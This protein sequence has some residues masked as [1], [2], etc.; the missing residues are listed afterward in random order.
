MI[1]SR[2]ASNFA[3]IELDSA[4]DF[5]RWLAVLLS[6]SPLRA[7]GV[8]NRLLRFRYPNLD[9]PV[10]GSSASSSSTHAEAPESSNK[11]DSK[12]TQ[13]NAAVRTIKVGQFELWDPQWRQPVTPQQKR[14]KQ[15]SSSSSS[16][17]ASIPESSKNFRLWIKASCLLKTN[18]E[19]QIFPDLHV[20]GTPQRI[21][22][23]EGF[24]FSKDSKSG[25]VRTNIPSQSSHSPMTG[26]ST[27][28]S[29]SSSGV[30]SSFLNSN[31]SHYT[32]QL[33][34]VRR[35]AIQKADP[36]LTGRQNCIVI[37]LKTTVD[38]RG[39]S[40]AGAYHAQH[41][42]NP[43]LS[44]SVHHHH[45]YLHHQPPT[46]SITGD[47]LSQEPSTSPGTSVVVTPAYFY[48]EST[49]LMEVWFVL[50]RSMSLPEL[51]G[52]ETGKVLGSFRQIRTL[53]VRIIDGKIMSPRGPGLSMDSSYMPKAIDS[54]VDISLNDKV[55]ARTRVKYGSEKPFWRE[56][57]SFVYVL[58]VY[59]FVLVLY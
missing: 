6:W 1:S 14:T 13:I 17:S 5:N 52:P 12:Q 45:Q 19:L 29:T 8:A 7:A 47:S 16:S 41:S 36:S 2:D 34:T 40:P 46:I 11:S 27:P 3:I 55:R 49:T 56:D 31:S 32:I 20:H 30:S 57:F 39:V 38:R 18:G 42:L 37:F 26:P 10:G 4:E 59:F 24:D 9:F 22:P 43:S 50:L 53:N 33:S 48:F 28:S 58:M 25:S 23:S 15:T 44:G 35:S 51:Y 21:K 54:Y